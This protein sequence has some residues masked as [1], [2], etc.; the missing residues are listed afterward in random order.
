MNKQQLLENLDKNNNI[1]LYFNSGGCGPCT[2]AKPLVAKIAESKKGYS[3]ADIKEGS[4]ESE[5]LG[6]FCGVEFYPTLVIIENNKVNR[7][8]GLTEIKTL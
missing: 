1:I 7:Y 4:I 8:V 2:Q 5:E 3:Y 6:K